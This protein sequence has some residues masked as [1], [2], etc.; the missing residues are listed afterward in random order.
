MS[1][2][3]GCGAELPPPRNP[4][5]PRRWCSGRCRKKTLYSRPCV[6]C[7]APL[8]GNAGNGP[9]APTRCP[10]CSNV[11]SGTARKVWTREAILMAIRDWA[12]EYGEP[13]SMP[14]WDPWR[15]RHR[16]GDDGRARRFEAADGRWPNFTVPVLEFGSWNAAIAA[17]GFEP[18]A[19]GG[20][21]GNNARRR[22]AAA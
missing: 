17:A 21:G 20:G 4:G 11:V 9:S 22:K 3:D 18:R 12:L 13:P 2:C 1:V 16:L 7:G 14:D 10:A 15:A 19:R 6:D 5:P 8:N